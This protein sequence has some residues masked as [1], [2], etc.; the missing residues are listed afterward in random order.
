MPKLLYPVGLLFILV[1]QDIDFVENDLQSFSDQ[2]EVW[3]VPLV[4]RLFVNFVAGHLLYV[5]K[6]I[7]QFW[8]D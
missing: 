8:I 3:R 1:R 2:L 7:E 5:A 4:P 6:D